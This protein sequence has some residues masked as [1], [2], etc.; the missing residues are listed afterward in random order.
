V[1]TTV[2]DERERSE[3]STS[4]RARLSALPKVD[5]HRHLEGSLR[6]QTLSEFAREHGIDLPSYDIDYLRRFATAADREQDFH[7]FLEK[8]RFLR[9]FYPTRAA[10]ERVAYEAVADAAADNIKYLELRFNPVALSRLQGFRLD[11]VTS[12]VCDAVDR[13]QRDHGLRAALILQVGREESLETASEISE[14]ALAHRLSGVVGIDL[15][16]DEAR[17]PARPFSHVFQRAR[18]EGLGVTVHAGEARGAESISEAIEMLG[19]QRIGHGVSVIKDDDVVQTAR[20]SGV[21]FEV[22]PTSNLQ[23]RVVSSLA[24]HP[25]PHMLDLGL[26]A[27]VNTDDPSVCDTTLTDEYVVAVLEMGITIGQ[28]R[29]TILTA[30]EGSFQPPE[31]RA[32]L[33]ERFR[34]E[35]ADL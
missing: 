9:R 3:G 23:T 13:A 20:R 4:L 25:L 31:E 26:R 8:F 7:S 6:L 30:I 21:T 11:E 10:V 19:A 33:T 16:G 2:S 28:I 29:S 18:E 35:L 22:C 34:Q 14:V 5:L 1:K 27:T 17:Y 32:R 24:L 15:A 12:W